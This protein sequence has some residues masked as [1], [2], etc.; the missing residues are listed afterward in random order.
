MVADPAWTLT[1]RGED[2]V[3]CWRDGRRAQLQGNPFELL[4]RCLASLQPST[5]P[6]LPPLGQLFGF[7]G[8]ELI[9][10]IEPSVPIH[11]SDPGVRPT[12]AGCWL[13]AC[14]FSIR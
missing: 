2:G 6:D 9:R 10:W 7:W 4:A 3:Q 5:I 11:P 1:V 8:Y 14:W 12:V 13:T